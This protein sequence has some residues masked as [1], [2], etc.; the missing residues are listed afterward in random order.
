M[1]LEEYFPA[2]LVKAIETLRGDADLSRD[3][4]A[5]AKIVQNVVEKAAKQDNPALKPQLENMGY[6]LSL[7]VFY[8]QDGTIPKKSMFYV[9]SHCLAIKKNLKALDVLLEKDHPVAKSMMADIVAAPGFIDACRN[10]LGKTQGSIFKIEPD[11]DGS[12]GVRELITG[13][14]L[15][16]FR[17]A[18]KQYAELGM[19][20][21][22]AGTAPS[23]NS[24]LRM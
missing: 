3:A 24:A 6:V 22:S 14:D 23:F 8:I 5:V 9:A 17:M 13:K 10:I 18:P 15:V 4:L 12:A 21:T 1:F 16:L 20:L 11:T 7:A 19:V 2:H